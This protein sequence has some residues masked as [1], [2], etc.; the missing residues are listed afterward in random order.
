MGAQMDFDQ[1]FKRD[2]FR[3]EMGDDSLG[4]AIIRGRRTDETLIDA[5]NAAQCCENG[6]GTPMTTATQTNPF[7]AH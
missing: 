1:R 3:I 5:F 6:L 4:P 7:Q 2:S